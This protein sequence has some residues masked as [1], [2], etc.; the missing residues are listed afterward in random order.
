MG[1]YG[2]GR[3]FALCRVDVLQADEWVDRGTAVFHAELAVYNG[4]LDRVAVMDLS[5]SFSLGKTH[6]HCC[7][8]V[9]F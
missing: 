4:N 9:V 6:C 3:S 5:Y 2:Y 8:A 1:T 7:D